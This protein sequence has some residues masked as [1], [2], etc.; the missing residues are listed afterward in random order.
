M[1][2]CCLKFPLL[3]K[4]TELG[5]V[6]YL[7]H[8]MN[9]EILHDKFKLKLGA[10]GWRKLQTNCV[11]MKWIL[12]Q[13]AAAEDSKVMLKINFVVCVCVCVCGRNGSSDQMHPPHTDIFVLTY[14]SRMRDGLGSFSILRGTVS[15]QWHLQWPNRFIFTSQGYFLDSFSKYLSAPPSWIRLWW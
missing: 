2:E 4:S 8:S 14:L 12:R 7:C 6:T 10:K 15:W 9:R 5:R 3:S 1:L 11:T 13:D